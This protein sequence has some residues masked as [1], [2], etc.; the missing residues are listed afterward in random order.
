VKY[1]EEDYRELTLTP[2]QVSYQLREHGVEDLQE[3]YQ[4]TG[5]RDVYK[6]S[7][8]LNFLGY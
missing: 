5:E 2:S 8:V 6:G 7:D 1:S 4:E 3:F